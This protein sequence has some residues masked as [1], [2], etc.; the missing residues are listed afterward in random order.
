LGPGPVWQALGGAL[1]LAIAGFWLSY[2]RYFL[3]IPEQQ[4]GP[5][6]SS[7]TTGLVFRSVFAGFR[8]LLHPGLETACFHFTVQTLL[9]SETHLLLAGLWAGVGLLL[10]LQ[11]L[12][13]S[14]TTA[15]LALTPALLSAPLTFVLLSLGGLRFIFD[16]PSSAHANWPFRLLAA[17]GSRQVRAACRK[18]LLVMGLIPLLLVW[19]PLALRQAGFR[20]AVS[21]LLFHLLILALAVELLLWKFQK[22]PFTCSFIPQRDRLLKIAFGSV[23]I[24]FVLLPMLARIEAIAAAQPLVL[25]L[26]LLSLLGTFV[27]LARHGPSDS[28]SLLY[29]DRSLESFAWLRLGKD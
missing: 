12:Q 27:W 28:Q 16:L 10:T 9:R 26:F 22:V 15:G 24:L 8:L 29:E 23:I 20:P 18:L 13:S 14:T 7:G 2:R 17:E 4:S 6:P 1:L 11:G 21:Y 25:A 5:S 19:F 3:R